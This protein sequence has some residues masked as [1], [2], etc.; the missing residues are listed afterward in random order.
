MVTSSSA[1]R[2]EGIFRPKRLGAMK[3]GLELAGVDLAS[4]FAPCWTC[5]NGTPAQ[6]SLLL[7]SCFHDSELSCV[8]AG[9]ACLHIKT[10]LR[11]KNYRYGKTPAECLALR[12][13]DGVK[14]WLGQIKMSTS[15]KNVA[16]HAYS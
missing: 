9:Q 15:K 14:N 6:P 11:S 10:P 12:E 8:Y 5:Q 7:A 2:G 13:W 1:V 4:I 3:L 16:I